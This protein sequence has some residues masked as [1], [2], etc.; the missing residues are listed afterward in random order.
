MYLNLVT[1]YYVNIYCYLV[2]YKKQEKFGLSCKTNLVDSILL[3]MYKLSIFC[4]FV[5]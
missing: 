4:F 2:Y 3:L 1:K 5:I